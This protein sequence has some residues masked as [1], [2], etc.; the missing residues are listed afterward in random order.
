M[1]RTCNNDNDNVIG[2]ASVSVELNQYFPK[3]LSSIVKDYATNQACVI[4]LG[5]ST[6]KCGLS[7]ND[8]PSQIFPSIVGHPRKGISID[9]L[10]GKKH[11]VGVD[12]QAKRTLLTLKYPIDWD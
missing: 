1:S 5:S 10:Q 4:D 7:T 11:F 12:A 8:K 6:I 2:R 9:L 3:E